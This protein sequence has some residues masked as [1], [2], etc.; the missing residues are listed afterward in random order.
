M[1]VRFQITE[2]QGAIIFIGRNQADTAIIHHGGKAVC[3]G[4]QS[5]P[6]PDLI[7]IIDAAADFGDG[8]GIDIAH[9]SDIIAAERAD[10]NHNCG[11]HAASKNCT[12]RVVAL[13]K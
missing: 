2:C 8:A 3:A 10:G 7:G 13:R 9:G 5:R 4:D 12:S 11:P 1:P 6:D